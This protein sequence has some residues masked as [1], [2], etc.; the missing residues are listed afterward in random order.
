MTITNKKVQLS[1]RFL[2]G[3]IHVCYNHT[4]V[5]SFLKIKTF[6]YEHDEIKLK[7]HKCKMVKNAYTQINYKAKPSR[8]ML[9]S[10][11]LKPFSLH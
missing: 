6:I 5:P 2:H 4:I 11:G 8:R 9:F 10:C 7:H 3:S 1:L